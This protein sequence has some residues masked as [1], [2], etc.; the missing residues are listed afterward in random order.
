[1]PHAAAGG[2]W[3]IALELHAD[4]LCLS[5]P[6]PMMVAQLQA[7][8]SLAAHVPALY[9]IFSELYSNAVEYGVLGLDSAKKHAP[10]GLDAY[11]HARERALA[12]LTGGW[13]RMTAVCSQRAH[14]GELVIRVA[15]SG[16]GFDWRALDAAAGTQARDG[17][18]ALVRGLCS[19]VQFE[20]KGSSVCALFAWGLPEAANDPSGTGHGSA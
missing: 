15:D 12:S 7:I 10:G 17:G 13:V 3:H 16:A 18:L 1:M 19:S 11:L 5:D 6:V 2:R 14:A 9:T 8:P 4:A 20:G